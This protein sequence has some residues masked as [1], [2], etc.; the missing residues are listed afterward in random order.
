MSRRTRRPPR[1]LAA[2]R[3]VLDLFALA[4]AGGLVALIVVA[5]DRDFLLGERMVPALTTVCGVFLGV[6]VGLLRWRIEQRLRDRQVILALRTEVDRGFSAYGAALEPTVLARRRRRFLVSLAKSRAGGSFPA[7]VATSDNYV[8]DNLKAE[9][10][11][12]S[13]AA[14]RSVITYYAADQAYDTL[15]AGFADGR[16]ERLAP[17]EKRA[18]VD[19]FFGIEQ[20]A[21]KTAFLALGALNAELDAET[22]DEAAWVAGYGAGGEPHAEVVRRAFE[23]SLLPWVEPDG[24]A[25]PGDPVA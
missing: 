12:L 7:G 22:F 14:I 5:V 13:D 15:V 17:D 11:R 18:L 25:G 24:A 16:F 10:P 9:L 2:G 3:V 4:L 8:F 20:Q 1:A 21:F 23:G 19:E 6:Y